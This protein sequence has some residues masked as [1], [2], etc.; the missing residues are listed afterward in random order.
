MGL[1][2]AVGTG[3]SGLIWEVTAGHLAF[4]PALLV[5]LAVAALLYGLVPGLVGA[6]WA[7]VAYGFI[8]GFFAPVW[9]LP[10]WVLD[11]SPFEHVPSIPLEDFVVTPVIALTVIAA[12]VGGAGLAAFRNRDLTAT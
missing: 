3:D 7:V 4:I 10:Q 1:G 6:V 5:I 9:D 2:A 12:A 11:I 8:M